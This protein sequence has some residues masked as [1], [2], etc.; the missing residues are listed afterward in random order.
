[1]SGGQKQRI[2]L[3][4]ATYADADVILLDDPLS[5]LD[6]QVSLIGL[7]FLLVFEIAQ[8]VLGDAPK[9]IRAAAAM[10]FD[11]VGIGTPTWAGCDPG[12]MRFAY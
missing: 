5:A 10:L 1:M 6:A 8:C 4:R 2:S 11:L 9:A 3:A 7:F 12:W